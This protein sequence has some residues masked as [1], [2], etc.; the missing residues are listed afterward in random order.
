MNPSPRVGDRCPA[1]P[2]RQE[3]DDLPFL[4]PFELLGL[5]Q[6]GPCHWGGSSAESI[7]WVNPHTDTLRI[8]LNLGAPWSSHGDTSNQHSHC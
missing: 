3:G 8:M 5:K 4:G 1:E 7:S 6:T 2:G